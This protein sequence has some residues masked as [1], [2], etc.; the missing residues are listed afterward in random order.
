M[1]MVHRL[2][3]DSPAD[4]E[5]HCWESWD[6]GDTWRDAGQLDGQLGQ[7]EVIDTTKGCPRC[8]A[9]LRTT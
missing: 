7:P 2:W 3:C 9:P 8:G 1:G 4:G 6:E 5:S